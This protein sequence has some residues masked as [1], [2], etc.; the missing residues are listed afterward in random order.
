M[1]YSIYLTGCREVTQALLVYVT[2]NL[3]DIN[4]LL[5]ASKHN[6][7]E[8]MEAGSEICAIIPGQLWDELSSDVGSFL[9]EHC[10]WHGNS[11]HE[12]SRC[13]SGRCSYSIIIYAGK[14]IYQTDVYPYECLSN[15]SRF[16]ELTANRRTFS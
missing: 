11:D 10:H 16:E 4:T 14:N 2:D 9:Y 1:L 12:L 7:I 3:E 13:K 6:E 5:N 15:D 8:T